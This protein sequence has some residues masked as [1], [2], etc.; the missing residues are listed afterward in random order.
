MRTVSDTVKVEL[1]VKRNELIDGKYMFYEHVSAKLKV[2]EEQD[3]TKYKALRNHFYNS[4]FGNKYN[5]VHVYGLKCI[6]V[7]DAMKAKA[8]LELSFKVED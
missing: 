7:T 2:L 1:K 5:I 6:D 8:S 4:S 3:A